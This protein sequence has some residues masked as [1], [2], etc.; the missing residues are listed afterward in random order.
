[1]LDADNRAVSTPPGHPA[2][3]LEVVLGAQVL[4]WWGGTVSYSLTVARELARL[5]HGITIFSPR[6]GE[7]GE[8]ARGWGLEVVEQEADL[9]EH[10]D[11]AYVQ[12]AWSAFTLAARYPAVPLVECVHGD[13]ADAFFPPQLSGLVSAVVTTY[14]RVEARARALALDAPIVRLA[15]P[16]DLRRFAPHGPLVTPPRRVLVMGNYMRGDRREHVAAACRDAGLELRY[17]GA[18]DRTTA[19]PELDLNSVDIVIGKARVIVEAMACGRAAYVYDYNGGDGWVT[20]ETYARHAADN[21]AG[22]SMPDV[23]D[24][25]GLRRDLA[26]YRPEMG[27]A[28][29]DL[30]VLHH[31]AARHVHALVDLFRDLAPSAARPP[32]DSLRE[33]ARLVALQWDTYVRLDAAQYWGAEALAQNRRLEEERAVAVAERDALAAGRDALL[34]EGEALAAELEER[35]AAGEAHLHERDAL[36]AEL[37]ERRV[38]GDALLR[39]RDALAAELEQRRDEWNALLATRR[40]RLA[41][42]LAR[43]LDVARRRRRRRFV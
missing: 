43:P 8:V 16:V 27:P 25:D 39:E 5:G 32:G 31:S 9:P 34:R 4:D 7:P 23:I 37:E 30:A 42:A 22:Q 3:R 35:R 1:M 10:C 18:N 15:Q 41:R 13:E 20:P 40:Y 26:A 11:V 36:A 19:T 17:V 6:V 28:N 38:A 2:A 14:D 29:R 12:D 33:M 21:F 24:A